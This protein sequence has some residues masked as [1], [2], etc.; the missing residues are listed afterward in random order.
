MRPLDEQ[1]AGLQKI[2][3]LLYQRYKLISTIVIK[4]GDVAALVIAVPPPDHP[5]LVYVTG[6]YDGWSADG[7]ER[8]DMSADEAVDWL[9]LGH[10]ATA[11]RS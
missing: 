7:L 10:E 9:E 8:N 4:F 11:R 5:Q 3:V 1:I 6:D 2:Q